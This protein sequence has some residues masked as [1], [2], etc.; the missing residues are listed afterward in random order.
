MRFRIPFTRFRIDVRTSGWHSRR[1]LFASRQ[2]LGFTAACRPVTL[3]VWLRGFTAYLRIWRLS[4][5]VYRASD[6][7]LA[8]E[9]ADKR[10]RKDLVERLYAAEQELEFLGDDVSHLH[11]M[12][13]EIEDTLERSGIEVRPSYDADYGYWDDDGGNYDYGDVVPAEALR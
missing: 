1:G 6:Y 10:D 3:S 7:E 11:R 5:N 12:L 8:A 13:Y 4:V 2:S 9:A